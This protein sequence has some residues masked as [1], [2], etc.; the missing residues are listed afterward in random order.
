MYS[1]GM[2]VPKDM[3]GI[4]SGR[5][6]NAIFM[7]PPLNLNKLIKPE[8]AI[9]RVL[10]LD[11]GKLHRESAVSFFNG[12]GVEINMMAPARPPWMEEEFKYLGKALMILRENTS[13]FTNREWTPLIKYSEGQYLG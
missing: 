8:F 2:A 4:V 9:F 13:V 10:T 11:E 1:E 5:V 12:Y 3:P 7:P 6:H